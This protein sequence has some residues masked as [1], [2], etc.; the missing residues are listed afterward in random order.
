[1]GK[2]EEQE[3]QGEISLRRPW[4]PPEVSGL[5][6][7]GN[8]GP[9]RVPDTGFQMVLLPAQSKG[10]LPA[11]CDL[12]CPTFL[13]L[14]HTC[15]PKARAE[16][17]PLQSPSPS[18]LFSNSTC[19]PQPLPTVQTWETWVQRVLQIHGQLSQV[20]LGKGRRLLPALRS[21]PASPEPPP[22]QPSS[23]ARPSHCCLPCVSCWA[24][25]FTPDYLTLNW[26]SSSPISLFGLL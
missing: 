21:T 2:G 16:S 4:T 1:M 18:L 7:I 19:E 6:S 15:Y 20:S 14:V 26:P 8:T 24:P 3:S 23:R 13:L 10:H 22:G 11:S 25:L 17:C 9:R 5:C 12:T